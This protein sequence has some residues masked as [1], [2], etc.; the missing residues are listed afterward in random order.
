LI[1]N[2]GT[3]NRI[4]NG[5]YEPISLGLA[6]LKSAQ[7]ND[8]SILMDPPVLPVRNEIVLPLRALYKE[9]DFEIRNS[10]A[11]GWQESEI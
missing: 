6:A 8:D 9:D 2:L 10:P 11:L 4:P 7:P 1:E 5:N 3:P